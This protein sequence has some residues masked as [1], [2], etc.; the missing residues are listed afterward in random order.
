MGLWNYKK[1]SKFD[2]FGSQYNLILEEI[3]AMAENCGSG[4][5]INHEIGV[6]I[7]PRK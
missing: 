7:C 3:G 6:S 5:I 4:W 2:S 1:R